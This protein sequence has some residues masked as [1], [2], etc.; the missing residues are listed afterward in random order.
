MDLFTTGL[1]EMRG[2]GDSPGGR[3][4][5][6][7]MVG[8][9]DSFRG[10]GTHHCGTA[11]VFRE[12]A[13]WPWRAKDQIVWQIRSSGNNCKCSHPLLSTFQG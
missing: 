5:L 11:V 7:I 8:L 1:G 10:S 6:A 13:C 4:C 12:G 3:A 9:S 2:L